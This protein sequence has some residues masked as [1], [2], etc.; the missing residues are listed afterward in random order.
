M[1]KTIKNRQDLINI[2]TDNEIILVRNNSNSRIVV[3]V[4]NKDNQYLV[5]FFE[6]ENFHLSCETN[7]RPVVRNTK[8]VYAFVESRLEKTEYEILSF[9]TKN[10]FHKF[11]KKEKLQTSWLIAMISDKKITW[12]KK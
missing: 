5:Y 2:S 4:K 1:V 7:N 12:V 8:D 10:E 3:Y 11:L 9:K 6:N